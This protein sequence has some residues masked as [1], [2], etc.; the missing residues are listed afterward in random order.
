MKTTINNSQSSNELEFAYQV[1]RALDERLAVMPEST[2]NRL[3]A[4]RKI[5]IARKK[6][7]SAA[8]AVAPARRF[9]GNFSHGFSNPFDGSLNWLLRVGIA[10]PLLILVLGSFGIYQYEQERR[11]NEL[12]ELDAAVLTDEL[13]INAFLDHGF[14]SYLNKHGE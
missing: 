8:Y 7:E 2:A 10:I 1:R 5:A 3:S 4:A 6:P 12:A 13:P 11:I 14:D 9:A